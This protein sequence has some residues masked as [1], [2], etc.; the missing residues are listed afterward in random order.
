MIDTDTQ[1]QASAN[2]SVASITVLD[3]TPPLFLG[4]GGLSRGPQQ[5]TQIV[6]RWTAI[7]SQDLD[8]AGNTAYLVYLTSA[9]YPALPTDPCQQ[10]TPIQTVAVNNVPAG[11][12]ETL[13]ISGL[14]ARNT[15]AVCVKAVDA[16]GN[17]SVTTNNL[18][19]TTYD[20][21]PPQFDG[22]KSIVFNADTVT[23]SYNWDASLSTDVNKY[24]IKAWK[25]SA[26]P[27]PSDITTQILDASSN[28]T[29]KLLSNTDFPVTDGDVVYGVVY[30]CDNAG[31][32]PGATNNC[33]TYSFTQAITIIIPDITPPPG[34]IGIT[35]SSQQGLPTEGQIDVHWSLPSTTIM[36]DRYRGFI[37]YYVDAQNGLH[38]LYDANC[39]AAGYAADCH[40]GRLYNH[41]LLTG[42]SPA[43]TYEL[44][45]RA[46][47]QAGNIT[48]LDVTTHSAVVKTLD[49][50]APSLQGGLA[51][52]AGPNYTLSWFEATDN[53]YPVEPGNGIT[54]RM[55]RKEFQTF[56]NPTQPFLDGIKVAE[57]NNITFTDIQGLD[58]GGTYYYTLCALDASANQSCDGIVKSRVVADYTPPVVTGLTLVRTGDSR[59]WSLIWQSSDNVEVIQTRV[60]RKLSSSATDTPTESNSL[61]SSGDGTLTELDDLTG[62]LNTNTWV[63]YLVVAV[64][65][66]GNEG[67]AT[68]STYSNNF[69]NITSVT[70]NQGDPNG[71]KWILVTA[72]GMTIEDSQVLIGGQTCQVQKFLSPTEIWCLT[73]PSQTGGSGNV[74]L[75]VSDQGNVGGYSSGYTYS[76]NSPCDLQNNWG[77][78][79][80]GSGTQLKPYIICTPQQLGMIDNINYRGKGLYFSLGDNLDLSSNN[81]IPGSPDLPPIGRSGLSFKFD[82]N[83]YTIDGYS[84]TE[85]NAATNY[86][87]LFGRSTSTTS[88]LQ[89]LAIRD[90]NILGGSSLAGGLF[91]SFSGIMSNVTAR[92]MTISSQNQLGGLV[93]SSVNGSFSSITMSDINLS[94]SVSRLASSFIGGVIGWSSNSTTTVLTNIKLTNL[95]YANNYSG[96]TNVA[97]LVGYVSSGGITCSYCSA[98][99]LALAGGGG[100]Y[101][102]GLFGQVFGTGITLDHAY[103]SGS[104]ISGGSSG[105]L[106]GATQALS[107]PVSISLSGSSVALSSSGG[108]NVGGLVGLLSAQSGSISNSYFSGSLGCLTTNCPSAVG[109]LI[110]QSTPATLKNNYVSGAIKGASASTGALIGGVNQTASVVTATG[111]FWYYDQA[112][113]NNGTGQ[114]NAFPASVINSTLTAS[115]ALNLAGMTAPSSYVGAG[116]QFNGDTTN[117]TGNF[118]NWAP[119]TTKFPVLTWQG[120]Q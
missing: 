90:F 98:S 24:V 20:V 33:S 17:T 105:G 76:V 118:W 83:N 107:G 101:W 52:G 58:Q 62:P 35:G 43:R 67:T 109:G 11:T 103:S 84:Y 36:A 106:I 110:G 16:A 15:Y 49:T 92:N 116:W 14:S 19:I 18:Q 96:V 117:G 23:V 5:D 12:A 57:T 47:D 91:G 37:I 54:Y 50:T 42:L 3:I 10:T 114:Q 113:L 55:Y 38:F 73:P 85:A 32:I 71:N 74:T 81:Q 28:S 86:T 22:L 112:N 78:F 102:S 79:A 51:F 8:P 2:R 70:R 69:I 4:I 56:L 7:N 75:V 27:L 93:G 99:G 115:S 21:T 89:N 25:G 48:P 100:N 40:T 77:D 68:V 59:S 1:N 104:I 45:V 111:V 41:Q 72:T 29:G 34:F 80:T 6:A 26:S 94:S 30:A 44:H 13:L 31:V 53:Q 64:D 39:L 65:A 119:N 9:A 97:G 87:G 46:Y 120:L 108:A 61:I 66:A 95:S 60:Y 82:G 88:S 63:N